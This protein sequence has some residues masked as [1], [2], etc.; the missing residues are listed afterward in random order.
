MLPGHR[1][2]PFRRGRI[3]CPEAC[4]R[5]APPFRRSSADRNGMEPDRPQHD[6]HR[7]LT[8]NAEGS[9]QML[10]PTTC[11][12]PQSTL[13]S[14][15][16]F[17][18]QTTRKSQPLNVSIADMGALTPW[19]L[20]RRMASTRLSGPLAGFCAN[21]AS[22]ARIEARKGDL[23]ASTPLHELRQAWAMT[24]KRLVKCRTCSSR[25]SRNCNAAR[26]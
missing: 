16:L 20:L 1:P 21:S 19:M 10:T 2:V 7:A 17:S 9:Q 6:C 14:S 5:P 26:T 4:S 24:Q 25:P 13:G 15:T 11:R 23:R 22:R 18:R 12:R 3:F 8:A